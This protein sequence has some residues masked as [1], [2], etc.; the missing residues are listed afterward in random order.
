M[1]K[2]T[3]GPWNWRKNPE[4]EAG[5]LWTYWVDGAVLLTSDVTDGSK[6]IANVFDYKEAP[7]NARLIAQAP[8][9]LEALESI[10]WK[11]NHNHDLPD[12]KGP[13]RITRKDATIRQ[14]TAAI[15][16]AKE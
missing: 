10:V 3:K 15:A 11:L 2:H 16:A 14:A 5:E 12:Y 9:L 4:P 6:P 1:A 13:A 7:A 8:A